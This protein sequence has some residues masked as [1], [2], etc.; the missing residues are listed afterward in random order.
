MI[1][2]SQIPKLQF[3]SR[4]M[5]VEVSRLCRYIAEVKSLPRA[6]N[7][8][9]GHCGDLSKTAVCEENRMKSHAGGF[10]MM[11]ESV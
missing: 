1:I 2:A 6:C 3:S 7:G 8:L 10:F 11:V 5:G 4:M 9:T